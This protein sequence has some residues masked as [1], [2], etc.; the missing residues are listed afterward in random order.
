MTA[1]LLVLVPTRTRPQNVRPIIDAWWST[2]AFEVAQLRFVIDK[3]DAEYPRYA[4]VLDEHQECVAHEVAEWQPLVPKL[5]QAARELAVRGDF[6]FIAFMGDD[7]L[8]RTHQW[9]HE[10]I[11]QHLVSDHGKRRWFQWG[12]DGLQDNRLPT[13]WSVD[14]NWIM[15]LGKMV[16]A[17]VE[18]LYCDNAMYALAKAA[19]LDHYN[20]DILVEHMHPFAQKGLVDSQ[21]RRV[22]AESQYHRDGL[23]FET[24]MRDG[25]ARDVSLLRETAGG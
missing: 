6:S 21:Y 12:R 23:A 10:L 20:E 22:N 9:A 15:A 11:E 4:K 2:G 3:D 1:E 14:R 5:N 24:W 25:L 7:H 8:P 18:H 13:W 19:D 17:P 16:P